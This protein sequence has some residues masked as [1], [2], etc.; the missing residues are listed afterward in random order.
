VVS[1]ALNSIPPFHYFLSDR[2]YVSG[3]LSPDP[4]PVCGTQ[5]ISTDYFQTLRIP[6]L[7]GRDFDSGD[8]VSSQPV[9][10][11][12]KAIAQHYFPDKSPIGEQIAFNGVI[13]GFKKLDYTIVGVAQNVRVANPDEAQPSYQAYF[14]DAQAPWF[15]ESL[16]LRSAGDPHDLIP[17][18]RKL[19]ASIDPDVLV[20]DTTTFD[21]LLAERSATRRLGV[22]LVGLFSGSALLLSAVGLYA[23]LAYSVTQRK[24]EI[25]VRIALGAQT[26]NVLR[27]VVRYGLKI[28]GTGLLIG[29]ASA[30]LLTRLIEKV[31]Y[32]VSSHDPFTLIIAVVILTSAGLLACLLPA[33]RAARVNP[34][35]VLRE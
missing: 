23:V 3:D 2:F 14:P 22:F 26:L 8:R 10:I 1:A 33:F 7:A 20:S 6:L 11:I 27:L 9:V 31:L 5:S 32:G 15:N 25:G 16:L 24:R 12:D 18:V 19:V 17:A 29:I 34:I 28:I 35:K 21:D 4:A 13:S 30:V